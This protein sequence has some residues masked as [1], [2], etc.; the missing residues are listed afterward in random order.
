MLNFKK[1]KKKVLSIQ[2]YFPSLQYQKVR[3]EINDLQYVLYD[4]ETF[5]R[6]RYCINFNSLK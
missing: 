5:R 2:N 3:N 6:E 1:S 4:V